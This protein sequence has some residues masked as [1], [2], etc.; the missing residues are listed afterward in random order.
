MADGALIP[1]TVPFFG[2]HFMGA[3]R[4]ATAVPYT[5]PFFMHPERGGGGVLMMY[6]MRGWRPSHLDYETWVAQG[7]PNNDN[8]SGEPVQNVTVQTA[9]AVDV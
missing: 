1:N 5:V 7:A 3:A 4:P 9:W 2:T 8:P 6:L